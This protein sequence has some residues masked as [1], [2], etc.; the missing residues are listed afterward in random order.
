MF[1]LWLVFLFTCIESKTAFIAIRCD[2]MGQLLCPVNVVNLLG[3]MVLC[4]ITHSW[5]ENRITESFPVVMGRGFLFTIQHSCK[6]SFPG[7][8]FLFRWLAVTFLFAFIHWLAFRVFLIPSRMNRA[9][10]WHKE[11][12]IVSRQ[13]R[14]F[15]GCYGFMLHHTLSKWESYYGKL[16]CFHG[17]WFFF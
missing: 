12:T 7:Q 6:L 4:F 9:L 5:N 3:A 15:G 2:M 11:S 1:I 10:F 16:P 8:R 17:P 14:E 13:W